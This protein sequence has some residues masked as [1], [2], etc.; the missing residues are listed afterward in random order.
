[1]ARIPSMPIPAETRRRLNENDRRWPIKFGM[2]AVATF[3]AFIA[4]ILFAVTTNL[5]KMKYGG[6]DWVDG[7][8][9]APVC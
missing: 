7:M 5:S 6:N 9:I 1:M 8:P 3:F 2:R 4:M